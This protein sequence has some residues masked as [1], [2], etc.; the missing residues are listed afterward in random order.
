M[1]FADSCSQLTAEAYLIRRNESTK[2]LLAPGTEC[3]DRRGSKVGRRNF[4]GRKSGVPSC[5][6]S[7]R[8]PRCP[9]VSLWPAY[10]RPGIDLDECMNPVWTIVAVSSLRHRAIGL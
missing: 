9:V 3:S 4:Q 1:E 7:I 2:C 8:R 10:S 6:A 5:P